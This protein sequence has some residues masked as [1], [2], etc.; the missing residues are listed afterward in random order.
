MPT[1]CLDGAAAATKQKG[2][3]ASA[4]SPSGGG[5]L[6][7]SCS[8]FATASCVKWLRWNKKKGTCDRANVPTHA[9]SVDDAPFCPC[10]CSCAML[11]IFD[12]KYFQCIAGF[13]Q[14]R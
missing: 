6:D 11:A 7:A 5:T 13:R 4:A 3:I 10:P 8:S 9:S 12:A 2:I 14:A 1:A